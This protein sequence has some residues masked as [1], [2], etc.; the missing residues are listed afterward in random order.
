MVKYQDQGIIYNDWGY[1]LSSYYRS[2]KEIGFNG[3][4]PWLW[5]AGQ[6]SDFGKLVK[7]YK[8]LYAHL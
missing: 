3:Q 8:T 7:Q 5:D 2:S 4:E 6:L 1:H